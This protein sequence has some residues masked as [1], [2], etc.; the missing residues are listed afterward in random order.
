MSHSS[1]TA[2]PDAGVVDQHVDD[3][4]GCLEDSCEAGADRLVVGHVELDEVDLD[5]GVGRHR[6]QLGRLVDAADG[7]VDGVT[8]LCKVDCGGA[9]DAAVGTRDDG[10][11]HAVM[12]NADD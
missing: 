1:A 5:T 9:A 8:L 11:G 6:L 12:V 4:V 10:D 3:A 7:A 2:L